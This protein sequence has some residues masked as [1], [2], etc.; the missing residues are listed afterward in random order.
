MFNY[1]F[2]EDVINKSTALAL[3][4]YQFFILGYISYRKKKREKKCCYY[5]TISNYVPTLLLF[6]MV[7]LHYVQIFIFKSGLL[8]GSDGKTSP[9]AE[10]S[11]WG[12]LSV[13]R[14]GL[15][16]VTISIEFYNLFHKDISCKWYKSNILLWITLICEIVC[17]VSI[18]SRGAALQ[19]ILMFFA[20]ISILY[21]G[22]SLRKILFLFLLGF[23]SLSLIVVIRSNGAF[24]FSFNILDMGMDLIINNYTLYI[25]YDYVQNN[26]Y[27]FFSLL[28]SLLSAIPL[29]QG[30]AV[31]LFN[32]PIYN[33]S[34]A[35][36][37]SL[38]VLGENPSFGVGT[39]IIAALYLAGGIFTVVLC[40]FLLGKF[41]A[42][43]SQHVRYCSIYKLVLFFS[44]MSYSVYLVR[45]D[46]F[47]PAGKIV[48]ALLFALIF[49]SVYLYKYRYT[50][51]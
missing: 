30:F 10:G 39:N 24:K 37:F 9:A 16:F 33:T 43:I 18:G 45:A 46:Y 5:G 15:I 21:G 1:G 40:M 12:Y 3:L 17:I 44:M 6:I 50:E 42:Y 38:L 31:R 19:I 23:L 36:F 26:G 4:G 7:I 11:I 34:S 25:G 32:I 27:V 2:N 35:R 29:L 22:I 20:G 47:Y 49:V 48:F 13:L 14:S 41:V 28:G 51:N 8:Y